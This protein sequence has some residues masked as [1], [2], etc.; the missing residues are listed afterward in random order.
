MGKVGA[1]GF[2]SG[3]RY[4]LMLGCKSTNL[5]AAVD[6]AGGFIIQTNT[7]PSVPFPLST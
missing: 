3:G 4:T 1:I 6:S 2:C 7:R 5:D